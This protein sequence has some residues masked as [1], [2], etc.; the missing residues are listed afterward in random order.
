MEKLAY[1]IKE[2][3]DALKEDPDT[4]ALL[5]TNV[6]KKL[7]AETVQF[8]QAATAPEIPWTDTPL[9]LVFDSQG[10]YQYT[11]EK[12]AAYHFCCHYN[13]R[14]PNDP[15]APYSACSLQ[16]LLD[17][18]EIAAPVKALLLEYS[19]FEKSLAELPTAS[20]TTPEKQG[21]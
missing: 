21:D 16:E 9:F 17:R 8:L 6:S 12:S 7:L 11:T 18:P 1:L 14:D 20:V 15:L 4:P 3:Q 19:K 5:T 13:N 2:L 10:L